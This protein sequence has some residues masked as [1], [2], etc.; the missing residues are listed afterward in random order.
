MKTLPI[1]PYDGADCVTRCRCEQRCH[2]ITGA[3]PL[4][5]VLDGVRPATHFV[6][7]RDLQQYENAVLVFGQPDVTHYV[8]DQR[9]QCEI[10]HGWDRVVFAKYGPDYRPSPFNYDDS[11]EPDDPAAKER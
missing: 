3:T 11:N 2:R 10:A 6:G 4:E 8:W 1:C 9:A 5:L 7:F